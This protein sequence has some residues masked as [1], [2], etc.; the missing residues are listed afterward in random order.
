MLTHSVSVMVIQAQAAQAGEPDAGRMT[1]ALRRIETIGQETLAELRGLLRQVQASRGSPSLRPQPGLDRIDE[2]IDAVRHAGVEVSLT[3]EGRVRAVPAG[4]GLSAYRIVQE[5]LTNTIRHTPG[6]RARVLAR[7]DDRPRSVTTDRVSTVGPAPSRPGTAPGQGRGIA[8]MRQRAARRGRDA[9]RRA[10]PE[11]GF[12]VAATLPL[13]R[14][15][16]TLRVIIADD[17]ELVRDGFRMILEVKR[18]RGA[19]RGAGRP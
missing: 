6:A 14:V 10:C 11:G 15:A 13:R 8:G 9:R 3:R 18:N 1:T 4:V 19:R 7:L 2:L 16:M 5:A 17:Q 12:R